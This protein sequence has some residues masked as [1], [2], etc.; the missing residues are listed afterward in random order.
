MSAETVASVVSISDAICGG[1]IDWVETIDVD[2]DDKKHQ[3]ILRIESDVF[4]ELEKTNHFQYFSFRATV[5]ELEPGETKKVAF[6]IENAGDVSYPVAW[7]G[8]TVFYT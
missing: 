8:T 2:G 3:V 5:N 1:N 6:V 4:S 7:K